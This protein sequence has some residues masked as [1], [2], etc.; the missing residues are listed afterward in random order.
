MG[1]K[2]KLESTKKHTI[3]VTIDQ[4]ILIHMDEILIKNKSKLINS[5][6]IKYLKTL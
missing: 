5:L 1:R 4:D 3:S 6:I 2:K